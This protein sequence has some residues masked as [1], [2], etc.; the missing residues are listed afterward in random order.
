MIAY[1]FETPEDNK[2]NKMH[3][4]RCNKDISTSL[5]IQIRYKTHKRTAKGISFRKP[6]NIELCDECIKSFYE[7]VISRE[8]EEA[9]YKE[10]Q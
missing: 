6:F 3:C 2:G 9:K 1:T 4:H 8:Q 7:Q 5:E 10:I